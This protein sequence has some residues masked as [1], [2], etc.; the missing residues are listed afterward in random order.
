MN[1]ENEAT[2]KRRPGGVL[3]PDDF[4]K[5]QY[6]I[7]KE[8]T[9]DPGPIRPGVPMKVLAVEVPFLAVT[10]LPLGQF[11]TMPIDIRDTDLIACSDEFRKAY[12][13]PPQKERPAEKQPSPSNE[14]DWAR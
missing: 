14:P 11:P 8:Y 13:N 3:V 9:G 7:V 4:E 2:S 12:A 6:V 1:D 5:G 10:P